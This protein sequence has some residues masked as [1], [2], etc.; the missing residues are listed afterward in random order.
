MGGVTMAKSK[1]HIPRSAKRKSAPKYGPLPQT[2]KYQAA[3]KE[4]RKL[5]KRAD[6]RLV[7]LERYAAREGYENVK[8]YAYARAMRDIRTWSGSDAKRFNTRP[9]SGY[10]DLMGK[11]NDIKYFLRSASS[12]IKPTADNAIY[13]EKG[14]LVGGGIDLTYEKRAQALNK[15]YGTDVSWENIG[16]LFESQLYR[17]MINKYGV[18]A[19]KS[20][21]RAI[22]KIQANDADIKR[23]LEDKK[24]IKLHFEK[25]GPLE[26][27]VNHILRYYKKDV[28]SLYEKL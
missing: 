25:E 9:P 2:A 15:R 21:V 5:A 20:I 6:Q 13:N 26:D 27:K 3:L 8:E 16:A 7:R 28:T 19:S 1:R 24:A 10:W 14:E 4:Y 18:Q 22:G 12:S 23:A 11:I 17:K